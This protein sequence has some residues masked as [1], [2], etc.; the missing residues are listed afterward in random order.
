MVRFS[1]AKTTILGKFNEKIS[2]NF[3]IRTGD[4]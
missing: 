2:Q 1:A 4:F 3:Q